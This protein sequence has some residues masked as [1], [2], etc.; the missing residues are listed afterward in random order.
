MYLQSLTTSLQRLAGTVRGS[1]EARAV[2]VEE[3]SSISGSRTPAASS[4]IQTMLADGAV[5]EG[6]LADGA[7]T[8][9]KLADGAVTAVKVA[10]GAVT[11]AGLAEGA[12]GYTKLADRSV[13]GDKIAD[14]AVTE[15]KL[16]DGILLKVTATGDAEDGETVEIPGP[17][18]DA[19]VVALT[20]V[21]VPAGAELPAQIGA[22]D[23][24]EDA[25]M[26]KFDASGNFSWA[27]LGYSTP[28]AAPEAAPEEE[29]EDE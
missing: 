4:I 1:A 22:R 17:F 12:V 29:P 15:A 21:Q 23:L 13:A 2:R 6:K 10:A 3:A 24:R 8:E 25:G 9:I 5:S 11:D 26:W 20:A 18:A 19:P 7:V 14:G 28:E 27:V 16:A